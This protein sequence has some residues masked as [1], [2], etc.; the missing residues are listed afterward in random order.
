MQT[1]INDIKDTIS[2]TDP[3]MNT[4]TKV[5]TIPIHNPKQLDRKENPANELVNFSLNST[6]RAINKIPKGKYNYIEEYDLLKAEKFLSKRRTNIKYDQNMVYGKASNG[7]N[8]ITNT[9]ANN[10]RQTTSQKQNNHHFDYQQEI[11]EETEEKEEDNYNEYCDD[12]NNDNDDDDSNIVYKNNKKE[13]KPP[14]RRRKKVVIVE[15][16]HKQT[17]KNEYSQQ[18]SGQIKTKSKNNS[19]MNHNKQ[20][21]EDV[22]EDNTRD[23]NK[24]HD[25]NAAKASSNVNPNNKNFLL[26]FDN[27]PTS[28][29]NEENNASNTIKEEHDIY[30][31]YNCEPVYV[32]CIMNNEPLKILK[33]LICNNLINKTSLNFYLKK[34]RNQ[35]VANQK[36]K[37]KE[38]R[39]KTKNQEE[40]QRNR[41][42][43]KNSVDEHGITDQWAKLI[44]SNKSR[45]QEK[46]IYDIVDGRSKMTKQQKEMTLN[47]IKNTAL[48]EIVK[49]KVIKDIHSKGNK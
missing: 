37:K 39:N 15:P 9:N 47:K 21:Y 27:T 16:H 11:K 45:I 48:E 22:N 8:S 6:S 30:S 5:D 34:Y 41:Q 31:C 49:R 29:I 20:D 7:S 12:N 46:I 25:Y 17:S 42:R 44:E 32:M 40:H 4:R 35:I 18:E 19:Q 28:L 33:C 43:E 36:I 1:G 38:K 10:I 14:L 2:K 24:S 13:L 26:L 3:N 23:T